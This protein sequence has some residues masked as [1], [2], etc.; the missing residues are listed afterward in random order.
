MY[1]CGSLKY[2]LSYNIFLHSLYFINPQLY[3]V[4]TI[5]EKKLYELN[6]FHIF[7]IPQ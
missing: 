7:E 3:V 5:Q 4:Q 1:L 2:V 6:K